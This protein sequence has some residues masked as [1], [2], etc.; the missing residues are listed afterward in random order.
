LTRRGR[1]ASDIPDN[2]ALE[3][4]ARLPAKTPNDAEKLVNVIGLCANYSALTMPSPALVR[5][6]G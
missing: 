1:F 4:V 2:A 3:R 6:D 5:D